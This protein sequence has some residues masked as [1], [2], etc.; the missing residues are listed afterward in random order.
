MGR[1]SNYSTEKRTM[2]LEYLK[3]HKDESVSVKDIEESLNNSLD[4]SVNVT[5]I[6]RYLDKLSTE[7][8]VLKHTSE[9]GNKSTYQ[10]IN[11]DKLCHNHL[12]MKCTSCGKVMHMDCSFMDEFMKHIYLHHG[13]N[14][15][16]KTSMIYGTCN[17]CK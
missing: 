12:H 17:G 2:I 5:T 4:K 8:Q 3:A 7:G 16:C 1:S 13:F 10:Y 11:P 14:I 9:N 6:Y 15:E